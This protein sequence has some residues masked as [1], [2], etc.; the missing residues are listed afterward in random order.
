MYKTK[1]VYVMYYS[2]ILAQEIKMNAIIYVQTFNRI[3]DLKIQK[4]IGDVKKLEGVR[5]K[6]FLSV[7]QF[8]DWLKEKKS[9]YFNYLFKN[10]IGETDIMIN[11]I[12]RKSNLINFFEYKTEV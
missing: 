4:E 5:E 7:R 8:K 1:N 6:V 11:F 10:E 9:E 2:D 12:T 3:Y